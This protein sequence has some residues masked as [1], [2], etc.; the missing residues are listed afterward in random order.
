MEGPELDLLQGLHDDVYQEAL[1]W[2]QGIGE[3]IRERINGQYGAMP[4]KEDNIQVRETV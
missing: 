4:E 2:Y 1:K 3:H